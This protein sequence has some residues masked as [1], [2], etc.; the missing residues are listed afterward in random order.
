M[1]DI[2]TRVE[3]FVCILLNA[4]QE[5]QYRLIVVVEFVGEQ[6]VGNELPVDKTNREAGF[7]SRHVSSGDVVDL[8][9]V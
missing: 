7:D 2:L 9:G 1:N 6:G 4:Q 3:F 5:L 8:E